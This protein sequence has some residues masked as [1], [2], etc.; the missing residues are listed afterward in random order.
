MKIKILYVLLTANLI[1][2]AFLAHRYLDV[3]KT[4]DK[5]LKVRG[6]VVVDSSGAER[7]VI[8]APLPHPMMLG[9]RFPRD[10]NIS[11]IL[12]YDADGEERS[13]YVTGDDFPNILFTLE[14]VGQQRALFLAE[15][16]GATSLLLWG[17]NGNKFALTASDDTT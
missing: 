8:G 3:T 6:L 17:D 5:V 16:Q 15:P 12:L 10:G 4:S 7:V 11:G 13:G 14:R 1:A 9:K 2:T